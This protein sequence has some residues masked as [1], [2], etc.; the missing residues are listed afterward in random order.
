MGGKTGF[1]PDALNTLITMADNGRRR[2][3]CA[4]CSIRRAAITTG[5]T[6]A[7][8]DYGYQNF[9]RTPVAGNETSEDVGEILEDEGRRL[10]AA[11]QGRGVRGP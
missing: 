1:T 9:A 5:D 7:L 11:A 8:F 2:S 4:W 6:R 3:W 10:R